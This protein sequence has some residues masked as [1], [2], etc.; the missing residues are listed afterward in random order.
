MVWQ[1]MMQQPCWSQEGLSLVSAEMGDCPRPCVLNRTLDFKLRGINDINNLQYLTFHWY[2]SMGSN[3][4][5]K[6]C[7]CFDHSFWNTFKIQGV[8]FW[9]CSHNLKSYV[10]F[11]KSSKIARYI[12]H[13]IPPGTT[14]K[15]TARKY[16]MK[17]VQN[18]FGEPSP[19]SLGHANPFSPHKLSPWRSTRCHCLNKNSY[20]L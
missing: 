15:F 4:G 17:V 14:V 19:C 3:R 11:Q 16:V 7:F 1:D 2:C 20:S 5:Q 18:L 6:S 12:L 9:S 8:L 10:S 13:T